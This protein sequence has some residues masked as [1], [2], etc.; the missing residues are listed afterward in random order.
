MYDAATR[1]RRRGRCVLVG[2]R[3]R[4]V[5]DGATMR[6]SCVRGCPGGGERRYASAVEAR[7]YAEA[8][9]RDPIDELGRRA[10]LGLFPLRI[11]RWWR[12][13]SEQ[14]PARSERA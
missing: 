6:W 5:A 2:H 11:A 1:R 14:R 8:L 9:D 7:R 3:Y 13:R 4:F 10:P 12:R